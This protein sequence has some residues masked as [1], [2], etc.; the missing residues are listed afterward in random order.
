MAYWNSEGTY[1]KE[2]NELWKKIPSEGECS[3]N[4]L[5]ILRIASK[6]YYRYFNDGDV[7]GKGELDLDFGSYSDYISR[8]RRLWH[9]D[10]IEFSKYVH[11]SAEQ[12][13]ALDEWIDD[14]I[15]HCVKIEKQKTKKAY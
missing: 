4:H 1:Q 13:K 12:H 15:L 2:N 5:E 3:E 6:I 9:T 11:D 8:I 7:I 14:I 10:E